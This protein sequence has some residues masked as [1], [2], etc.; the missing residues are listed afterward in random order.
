MSLPAAD[1]IFR[2]VVGG[3]IWCSQSSHYSSHFPRL[4]SRLGNPGADEIKGL[5]E[6]DT[7][8]AHAQNLYRRQLLLV[9]RSHFLA[10]TSSSTASVSLA[11]FC[12]EKRLTFS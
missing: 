4:R 3:Q 10:A 12:Q 5:L 8:D 2:T 9:R 7:V 6:I 11:A 1:F